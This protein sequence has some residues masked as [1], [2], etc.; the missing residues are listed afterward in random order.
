MNNNIY[1]KYL[2]YKSKYIAKELEEYS[3][4]SKYDNKIDS[5][6]IK[7]YYQILF[8]TNNNTVCIKDLGLNNIKYLVRDPSASMATILTG[9][10]IPL[11]KKNT[12]RK[13]KN[14]IDDIKIILSYE[15]N[16]KFIENFSK[17]INYEYSV[18]IKMFLI[19][20]E[21]KYIRDK[22]K[23][24]KNNITIPFPYEIGNMKLLSDIILENSYTPNI[25]MFYI[26][27]GCG[28]SFKT[29]ESICTRN[30]I[31]Q[32]E[33][34]ELPYI[35]DDNETTPEI[36]KNFYMEYN[37]K[38]SN[39]DIVS[40]KYSDSVYFMIVEKCKG[41][42]NSLLLDMDYLNQDLDEEK[43]DYINNIL[44]SI[45]MQSLLTYLIL[46][47]YFDT[48]DYVF[49]HGDF[50]T[51]NI[52]YTIIND[53][54]RILCYTING[55]KYY[56]KTYGIIVKFWDFDGCNISKLFNLDINTDDIE[57]E[58]KNDIYTKVYNKYYGYLPENFNN[59]EEKSKGENSH[60][61]FTFFNR[62]I[63]GFENSLTELSNYLNKEVNLDNISSLQEDLKGKEKLIPI[64]DL[65]INKLTIFKRY[66]FYDDICNIIN[67]K[68]QVIEDGTEIK[69]YNSL[70]YYKEYIENIFKIYNKNIKFDIDFNNID[71]YNFNNNQFIYDI[72]NLLK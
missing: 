57:I 38:E 64:I 65:M 53:K 34:D 8:T 33:T 51:N 48:D 37:T 21:Y 47:Y 54:D 4:I 18:V 16:Y 13:L 32:N 24:K 42:I 2:K 39:G 52:L 14:I 58:N 25:T 40:N 46:H 35:F 72:I 17:F 61:L 19:E 50:H 6:M 36:I 69:N 3:E 60:D 49:C 5:I 44:S 20:C 55:A 31:I 9:T 30:K 45:I 22:I 29:I 41:S 70:N 12:I 23:R 7:K 15:Q 10:L 63:F 11:N 43:I 67:T 56:V 27:G 66:N 1:K 71:Y 59:E 26:G 28:T 62:L 68:K